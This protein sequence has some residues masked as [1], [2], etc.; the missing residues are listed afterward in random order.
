MVY[1]EMGVST[2]H[3]ADD[4]VETGE[5]PEYGTVPCCTRNP[6]QNHGSK[7]RIPLEGA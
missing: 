1:A 6:S 4:P 7:R 2:E 5:A 3:E